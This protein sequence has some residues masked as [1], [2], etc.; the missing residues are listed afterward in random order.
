MRGVGHCMHEGSSKSRNNWRP[1]QDF[2]ILRIRI[3]KVE[4]CC[5]A[6]K[7]AIS[8]DWN[9]VL[10]F[11]YLTMSYQSYSFLVFAWGRVSGQWDGYVVNVSIFL[12]RSRFSLF[13]PGILK[14]PHS[15]TSLLLFSMFYEV[16]ECREV[17]VCLFKI[18]LS[19][20]ANLRYVMLILTGQK[21]IVVGV[22]MLAACWR[23]FSSLIVLEDRALSSNP[24]PIVEHWL[25]ALQVTKKIMVS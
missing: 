15:Q 11:F 2:G 4:R 12:C 5:Y 18:W 23:D 1:W 22:S 24:Q 25:G 14:S 19:I 10:D 17:Y 7:F 9:V 3:L 8:W 20:L 13:Y 16:S 6:H 21:D